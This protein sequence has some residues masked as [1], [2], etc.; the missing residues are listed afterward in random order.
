MR[1]MYCCRHIAGQHVSY[2]IACSRVTWTLLHFTYVRQ[3]YVL[4]RKGGRDLN[5][6]PLSH[7]GNSTYFTEDDIVLYQQENVSREWLCSDEGIA[8]S[9]WPN[10]I[11]S[12]LASHA[13]PC[14][15]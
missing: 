11:A 4:Y 1:T 10:V 13:V 9:E 2:H 6:S 15:P 14:V 8:K 7:V 5:L 12:A 3:F